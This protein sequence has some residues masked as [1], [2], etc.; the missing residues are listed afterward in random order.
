DWL[1]ELGCTATLVADGEAALSTARFSS[2]DAVVLDLG[3][4]G[5]DGREVARRLRALPLRPMPRIVGLSAHAGEAD[6]I[7]SLAA[8]MDTFLSKPV[9]LTT[10]AAA[11]S[12]NTPSTSA[13]SVLTKPADEP[14]G[15]LSSP[16]LSASR[17]DTLRTLARQDLA[18][19]H[20]EL[21]AALAVPDWERVAKIAHYL[22][23]TADLLGDAGLRAACVA[24]E[25]AARSG[26]ASRAREAAGLIAPDHPTG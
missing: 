13:T 26:D 19:R 11:L 22:A 1:R 4:P 24:C 18:A 25:D 7:S 20:A 16:L 2:F 23:N 9:Q 3:M 6:R 5:I 17:A 15:L 8:G 12:G 21:S 10:L 14:G